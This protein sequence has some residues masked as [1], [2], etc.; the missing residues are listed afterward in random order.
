MGK[1][2][3]IKLKKILA[4]TLAASVALSANIPALAVE[5]SQYSYDSSA[6]TEELNSECGNDS[7]LENYD[8]ES[9]INAEMANECE[10]DAY[11]SK[12]NELAEELD[13]EESIISEEIAGEDFLYA[14]DVGVF[15][16]NTN[17]YNS[18]KDGKKVTEVNNVISVWGDEC[19]FLIN[20][21]QLK[22]DVLDDYANAVNT[23]MG[24]LVTGG[25]KEGRLDIDTTDST[26]YII[27]NYSSKDEFDYLYELFHGKKVSVLGDSIS[28]LKYNIPG[29]YQVYYGVYGNTIPY[30]NM[31]W[32]DIFTRFGA[33]RGVID[34]WSGSPIGSVYYGMYTQKR[35]TSLGSNGT[36][37]ILLYY[38][39]SNRDKGFTSFDPNADYAKMVTG[40]SYVSLQ[41]AYAQSLQRI[42]RLYPNVLI[43][44]IIPYCSSESERV[45]EIKTIA[46]Y[47]NIVDVDLRELKAREVIQRA[48]EL[49]PNAKG[50]KQIAE[51]IC[52]VLYK[53]KQSNEYENLKD[54]EFDS[55]Y[56]T[57]T[58]NATENGG[59]CEITELINPDNSINIDSIKATKGKCAQTGW[60][61]Q[62]TEGTRVDNLEDVRFSTTLYAQFE[63]C[64]HYHFEIIEK[65]IQ[66]FNT[67]GNTGKIK[68]ADCGEIIVNSSEELEQYPATITG[69]AG[70]LIEDTLLPKDWK[71]KDLAENDRFSENAG[72]SVVR[73][74]IY[75]GDD[76]DSYSKDITEA[77]ITLIAESHSFE[78]YDRDNHRCSKCGTIELHQFPSSVEGEICAALGCERVLTFPHDGEENPITA[79]IPE[80]LWVTGI[81]DQDYTGAK[82][83]QPK[84]KVYW[85]YKLLDSNTDYSV[86]YDN[87]INAGNNAKV[88]ITGKGN[89]SGTVKAVYSIKQASIDSAKAFDEEITILA[90]GKNQK[91]T[92]SFTVEL[93]GKQVSLKNGTDYKYTYPAIREKGEYEVV[94]NGCGNYV[95][96]KTIKVYVID[97]QIPVTKLTIKQIPDQVYSGEAIE[98]KVSVSYK[99]KPLV[100][101]QDYK[102]TY[103]NQIC[104]GTA[105]ATIEGIGEYKGTK[106]VKYKIVGT[107]IGKATVKGIT[108]VVYSG[109]KVDTFGY[110]L[111]I[112]ATKSKEQIDLI[113]GIDY[114]V[115]VER[116]NA[117]RAVAEFTGINGYTGVLKKYFT[118]EKV[119]MTNDRISIKWP[120]E[121]QKPVEYQKGGSKPSLI[122]KDGAV[123]LVEGV[124]YTIQYTNNNPTVLSSLD[125]IPTAVV[126][127]KGNYTGK[128]APVYFEIKGSDL[129]KTTITATD[130]VAKNKAD[131]CKPTIKLVDSNGVALK[132]GVDYE[133]SIVYTYKYLTK[134]IKRSNSTRTIEYLAGTCVDS[135][136]I[137]PEGTV[138]EATV[139]GKGM[140]E[141]TKT[142]TFRYVKDSIEKVKIVIP[143]MV[144]TQ[145]VIILDEDTITV[146]KGTQKNAEK[147]VL[148]KDFEIVGYKDNVNKGTAKVTIKG[149]G[150]YGGERQ[151]SFKI[152]TKT[153][154][155]YKIN[156]VKNNPS[157]T[158]T[159][160]SVTISSG[161]RLPVNGYKLTGKNLKCWCTEPTEGEGA[162][163]Y[164]NNEVFVRNFVSSILSFGDEVTLYA[165]WE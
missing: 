74:A 27:Y 93:N 151:V 61:T 47:H 68:C 72:E 114:T 107:S 37:D 142:V 22:E 56:R 49:H 156:F 21:K 162:K 159:M 60:Y 87:N 33:E 43:V 145:K 35:I 24:I 149:I 116:I 118:I 84:L 102:V 34:A 83:E 161:T 77:S 146:T 163:T 55:S 160:K 165:I 62:P 18:T 3:G 92:T 78:E 10:Q 54:Y 58:F 127:G 111:Y 141:G 12:E 46:E 80:Q 148:G 32:G 122:V 139:T 158:G 8:N 120:E 28:T 99:N 96:S 15:Q 7:I 91:P 137:I 53:H 82:I 125:K 95:G 140:Y 29:N 150:N 40:K 39:G 115:K 17:E 123:M 25:S 11:I 110:Q 134:G 100:L 88:V 131:I 57:I 42:R 4:F 48:N 143:N 5:N 65:T 164:K 63:I 38:G 155:N 105:V 154:L 41:E 112:P 64:Q 117:G 152:V 13:A 157:A 44:Q 81:Y 138:I 23:E 2:C 129:E 136:D 70:S 121:E 50:Q 76:K 51:Y 132:A 71:W 130:V 19:S 109:K 124:D 135:K 133:K 104:V 79:G 9:A 16:Q 45:G 119:L 73:V 1:I 113:P 94:I 86:K 14:G 89:Y 144:Y 97:E 67:K 20:D 98:P 75:D 66:N 126:V 26:K 69:C 6:G 30:N 31:Y 90:N 153:F 106:S 85:N 36:P 59:N 101:D 52:E 103:N 128:S 147:L 108:S